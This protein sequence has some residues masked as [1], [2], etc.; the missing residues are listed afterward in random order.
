MLK[1]I[2]AFA[3]LAILVLGLIAPVAYATEETTAAT[4]AEEEELAG[5]LDDHFRW[6]LVDGT[7]TIT[8][9]GVMPGKAPWRDYA[10]QIE[11]LFFDGDIYTVAA[12]AF[13]DCKNLKE[14]QFSSALTEI[15]DNAFL[16]CES[17]KEI[18]LPQGFKRF[19]A[20]SF[21]G[22]PSLRQVYCDGYM[23]RF[24][25]ACLWNEERIYVYYSPERAW[26]VA[27]MEPLE[28]VYGG[29]LEF[30]CQDGT[31]PIPN[32]E[33]AP[34]PLAPAAAVTETVPAT[35][36]APTVPTTVATEPPTIPTVPETTAPEITVPETTA[37]ILTETVPEPTVQLMAPTEEPAEVIEEET[38][39]GGVVGLVLI[40]GVLTFFIVGALV[41]KIRSRGGRY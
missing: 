20:S 34:E 26:K 29:R 38:V 16:G 17:I 41:F 32:G 3:L 12:G 36:E 23:P 8:G 24:S 15:G 27:D 5:W 10:D 33:D 2:L 28:G 9:S 6:E 22:C 19:G 31:D 11:N 1:R 4:E 21:W 14:I 18:R 30:L 39:K 40:V 7:L 37:V 35:T 25:E 13:R